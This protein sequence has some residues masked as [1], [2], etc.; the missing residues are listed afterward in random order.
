MTIEGSGGSFVSFVIRQSSILWHGRVDLVSPT[1]NPAL[2][3]LY[4]LE[5][6]LSEK[7]HGLSASDTG[8]AVGHDIVCAVELVHVGRQLT[9]RNQVRA[10]NPADLPFLRLAHVQQENPLTLV[11]Q[12]L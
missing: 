12:I 2:E 4:L 9:Q 6:R 8:P 10:G 11:E 3:I 1:E 7:V 5:P